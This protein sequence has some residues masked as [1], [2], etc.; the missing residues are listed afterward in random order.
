[1]QLR[2][3]ALL[4]LNLMTINLKSTLVTLVVLMLIS[5]TSSLLA[6]DVVVTKAKLKRDKESAYTFDVTLLHEDNGWSHY[7]DKWRIVDS[8]GNIIGERLLRHPHDDEQ[9]FERSLRNSHIT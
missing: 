7:A 2:L 5:L 4:R 1:M 6:N 8:Q 3:I 9:P